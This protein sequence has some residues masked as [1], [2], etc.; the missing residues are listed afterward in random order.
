MFEIKGEYTDVKVMIDQIEPECLIQIIAMANNIAFSNPIAIMPDTHSGKGSVIGFTMKLGDKIIPNIVGVDIGCGMLSVNIGDI[1][2]DVVNLDKMIRERVPFGMNVRAQSD[3]RSK[4]TKEKFVDSNDITNLCKKIGLDYNYAIRSIGS[5]GSGNHFCE[6]GIDN[7]GDK[8]I[9][10]H[11][12]SRNLGK[13]VCE[14]WQNVAID[15]S[16]NKGESLSD[17]VNRIK[18]DF[19]K[20]EWNNEIGNLRNNMKMKNT[21]STGLEYLEGED[22]EGYILDM[23]LAQFYAKINRQTIR[24]VILNILNI[25]S[26]DLIDQIETVHNYID[27]DDKIIR[28]GAIR[29]YKGEM[30]IIPWN[31]RDGLIIAE[32]K[33][34]PE[35]NYSAPHGAGRVLSRSKA[36]ATLDIDK[37]KSDMKGIY[38]TSVCKGTLDEAPM[39]YKDSKII[40]DAIEPTVKILLKVKPIHNL[41]DNEE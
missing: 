13:K 32:G 36:K 28:K 18:R 21:R 6:I 15:R 22:L 24:N 39:A 29:A 11:T 14:Y 12:G 27:P 8:W 40:E 20:S 35:W 26:Y 23:Y 7:K 5:L 3:I 37:F 9:T 16:L 19:P 41:K 38:S 2:I 25:K 30:V 34:N 4:D 10:I 1:D 33:S 17:G 31:M